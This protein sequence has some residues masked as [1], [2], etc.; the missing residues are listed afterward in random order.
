MSRKRIYATN[1]E[2]QYAY[3]ERQRQKR[4]EEERKQQEEETRIQGQK[5]R[6]EKLASTILLRC[7]NEHWTDRMCLELGKTEDDANEIKTMI[8]KIAY[9]LGQVGRYYR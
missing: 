9:Q 4:R 5:G 2:R 1:A 3:D 8:Q 7:I 6:A